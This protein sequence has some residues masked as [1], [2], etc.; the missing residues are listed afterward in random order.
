MKGIIVAVNPNGVIGCD[1][2]IPWHYSEDL[3]RFKKLT[4][5]KTIIMGRKTWES[6]P[7][8]PLPQRRNVVITSR[9]IKGVE[10]FRKIKEALEDIKDEIWFIGGAGIYKEALEYADR[11]DMTL[12]PDLVTGEGECVYFPDVPKENW[13]EILSEKNK[14][15]PKLV[16]KIFVKKI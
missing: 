10:C 9:E 7:K 11:I 6:L 2:D 4:L 12:V 14:Y 1:G 15:N 13:E 8:K 5:D 16:Q 3:K